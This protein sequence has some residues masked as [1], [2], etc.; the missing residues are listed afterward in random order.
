[1]T[2]AIGRVVK[3]FT[4]EASAASNGR[5]VHDDLAPA[6]DNLYNRTMLHAMKPESLA[7]ELSYF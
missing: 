2:G 1:M 3:L 4:E 7:F 6:M 5:N